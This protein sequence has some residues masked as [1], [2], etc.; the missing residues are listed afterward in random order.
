MAAL[1]A[2]VGEAMM[3]EDGVREAV[4]HIERLMSRHG[5]AS[6]ISIVRGP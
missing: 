4:A 6:S 1:A 5:T 2:Q 3:R